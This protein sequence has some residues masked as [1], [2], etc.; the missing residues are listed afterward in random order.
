VT[1]RH[2]ALRPALP[3]PDAHLLLRLL[4]D[5]QEREHRHAIDL[6]HD[7]PMQEFTAVLLALGRIRTDLDADPAQR[8][9]AVETRLRD[10]VTS[11]HRPPAALRPGGCAG[12]TLAAALELRVAGLLADTLEVDVDVDVRPPNQAELSVLLAVVQLLLLAMGGPD[13]AAVAN[14]AVTVRSDPA[15]VE[16]TLRAVPAAATTP[17]AVP[18]PAAGATAEPEDAGSRAVRLSELAGLL[19]AEVGRDP[20]DGVW[21]AAF[22]IPRPVRPAAREPDLT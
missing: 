2:R 5:L 11:L 22:S 13:G 20:A 14:A 8:L 3:T 15:G 16:L 12:A 6:L 1:V 17:A 21:H 19:G 7:G 9:A 10:A 18:V 4:V